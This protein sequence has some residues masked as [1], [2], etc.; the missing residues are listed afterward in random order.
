VK[1]KRRILEKLDYDKMPEAHMVLRY[2]DQRFKQGLGTIIITIG[3]PGS[4]KSS[5]DQR[6]AELRNASL[7]EGQKVKVSTHT[8]FH[9]FVGGLRNSNLGDTHILE[10]GS[11][12]F[13]SR[14]AMS[15]DNVDLA[16]V[17][18]TCRKKQIILIVNA[19]FL[20]SLDSHLRMSG[21]ILIET[22]S[23][24]KK[25]GVV[26][27]KMH[28]LQ[29][30]PRSSKIYTHTFTEGGYDIPIMFTKKPDSK[31]WSDY[32]KQKDKSM[33]ELYE[34]VEFRHKKKQEKLDK[35]M[36]KIIQPKITKLS[37]R[38]LEVH[39]LVNI[40]GLTQKEAAK[41]LGV[42]DVRVCTIMKNIKKKTE[43]QN[44]KIPINNKSD[45]QPAFNIIYKS[46]T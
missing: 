29:I 9:P 41:S 23:I 46:Q 6:I 28:R 34:R 11:V 38:E 45:T 3:L 22:E 30:N 19:P 25:A 32:E 36:G 27:S 4:G 16:A 7:P 20:L 35:E 26:I 8:K 42:S 21:D 24:D 17:L 1:F 44:P 15:G 14:R 13:P 33:D 12:L 31:T 40:N 43:I 5:M 18:D 39:N 37:V 2:I 10:E